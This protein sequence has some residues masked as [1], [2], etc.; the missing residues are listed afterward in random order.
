[1]DQTRMVQDLV[2]ARGHLETVLIDGGINILA[3]I[4]ILI[5]GW[6]ISARAA[7]LTRRSLNRLHHFDET[8]KPLVASVVRYAI[9]V[10]TIVAVLSRFGVETT[11]IIT[12]LGAGAL[13]V[14]LALQGMLSNVA[15]GVMLL[16]L[17][18]FRIGDWVT[19]T[20][21]NQ[22]GSVREVGLFTT[23]L[24]S[25]D[26]AVVCI[27]NSSIFSSVIV[28]SS[29]EP[30]ARINFTVPIDYAADV[31]AALKIILEILKNDSRV[32]HEPAPATAIQELKG[33]ALDLLVRCWVENADGEAVRFAVQKA[34]RDKFRDADIAAPVSRQLVTSRDDSAKEH[35][36]RR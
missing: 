24:L 26:L 9:L 11:S 10:A 31:D 25:A 2:L 14:G 1:M 32:L 28:N 36:Q 3:A 6:L 7:H 12:I 17:R 19:V 35:A 4:A 27:P 30:R 15:A 23:R 29:L 5:V 33:D 34:I 16:I 8:L 21:Q 22:S 13:G 18:P 20:A